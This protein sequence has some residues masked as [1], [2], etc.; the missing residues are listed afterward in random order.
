MGGG[1]AVRGPCLV[2]ARMSSFFVGQAGV[3]G[4]ATDLV[5]RGP[6]RRLGL[7][8]RP[9]LTRV[10]GVLAVL[11]VLFARSGHL[12]VTLSRGFFRWLT[13]A[14]GV[15]WYPLQEWP[16]REPLCHPHRG[17]DRSVWHADGMIRQMAARAD[18]GACSC[19]ARA[20]RPPTPMGCVCRSSTPTH[21]HPHHHPCHYHLYNTCCRSL[22]EAPR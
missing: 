19:Q 15:A 3:H 8:R 10:S 20:V 18:E 13:A 9:V 6:R 22:P 5:V 14:T 7:R 2:R 4:L 16:R 21:H 12:R 17:R 11:F 1:K